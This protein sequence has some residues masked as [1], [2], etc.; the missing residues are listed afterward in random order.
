MS[1]LIA[2]ITC[3]PTSDSEA[4]KSFIPIQIYNMAI[5]QSPS[6]HAIVT[7]NT[8]AQS[9]AK[10]VSEGKYG[11]DVMVWGESNMFHS[12][13]KGL[14]EAQYPLPIVTG[15]GGDYQLGNG[16]RSN[17]AV[18][19]CLPPLAGPGR[20][21]DRKPEKHDKVWESGTVSRPRQA[22]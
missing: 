18:P 4:A 11:N 2:Y 21:P 10:G 8:V 9:E 15:A 16:K 13:K 14:G 12:T 5:S 22:A 3:I 19:Q 17:L 7:L 1:C 6:P 20:D